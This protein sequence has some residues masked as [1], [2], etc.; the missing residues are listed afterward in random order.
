M[1]VVS[2]TQ[3]DMTY[4]T[5][6]FSDGHDRVVVP[7]TGYEIVALGDDGQL[8]TIQF[9]HDP[10]GQEIV[11]KLPRPVDVAP[12]KKADLE[13]Y[14]K[15][16]D[17]TWQM[18]KRFHAEAVVRSAPANVLTA[19]TNRENDAWAAVINIIQTWRTAT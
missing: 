1:K 2:K 6:R 4:T 11:D 3:I 5:G 8:H 15:G 17:A 7:A 9:P 14:L 16:L 10:T 19:L 18:W 12:T 13:E